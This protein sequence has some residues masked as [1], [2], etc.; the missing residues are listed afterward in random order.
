[1]SSHPVFVGV[2]GKDNR[3][4]SVATHISHDAVLAPSRFARDGTRD[5][6]MRSI[7][8]AS[9]AQRRTFTKLLEIYA[10]TFL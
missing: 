8:S 9:T 3:Y 10:L 1:M 2:L 6:C 5:N 7:N 4:K